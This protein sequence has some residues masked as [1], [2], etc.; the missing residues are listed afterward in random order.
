MADNKMA[1]SQVKAGSRKRTASA[2]CKRERE[3][4]REISF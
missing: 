3:K 1:K 2:E 4:E